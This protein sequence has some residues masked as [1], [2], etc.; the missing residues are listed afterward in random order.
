MPYTEDELSLPKGEFL[1]AYVVKQGIRNSVQ[2][3]WYPC[4]LARLETGR[5][6]AEGKCMHLPPRLFRYITMWKRDGDHVKRDIMPIMTNFMVAFSCG[7]GRV[8]FILQMN[9]RQ[10]SVTF[11]NAWMAAEEII[12]GMTENLFYDEK[13]GFLFLEVE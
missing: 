12:D 4:W 2:K 13:T 10:F 11:H 8:D 1:P 7:C 5:L 9:S 3:L 6:E